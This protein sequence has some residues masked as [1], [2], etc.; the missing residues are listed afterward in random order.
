MIWKNF[1]LLTLLSVSLFISY[2]SIY[3]G[4]SF[5]A[6]SFKDEGFEDLGFLLI[7]VIY[8]T[9][10]LCSFFSPAIINII[11]SKELGIRIG[12]FSYFLYTST[13]MLPVLHNRYKQENSTDDVPFYLDRDFI[14]GAVVFGALV[15]G[16]G[17]G[18][19]HS[20]LGN[21]ISECACEENK[22]F[23]NAFFFSM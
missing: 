10:G 1:G 8:L 18:I 14:Q 11:G 22:G 4:Q 20:S 3:P 23:Y 2:S 17:A 5:A 16:L 19:Q 6:K 15:N 7:C 13:F 21:Y 12:C 9:M